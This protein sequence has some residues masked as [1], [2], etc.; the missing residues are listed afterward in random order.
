MAS[1]NADIL[2][3]V[4]YNE[5]SLDRVA[6]TVGRVQALAK[7][8]K[9]IN[10]LKPGA[11]AGA[12]QVAIAMD[13]ILQR[14]KAINKEGTTQIS[15]T[16]AGAAQTAD[17]FAEVLRNV[18][19]T[20]KNGN[21]ELA[22]QKAEV[23]ELA[24]AYAEAAA[25]SETLRNR[26]ESLIAAARQSRGLAIGPAST[27]GTIEADSARAEAAAQARYQEQISKN[28]RTDL[29]YQRL[30][31]E[32]LS[33]QATELL[34]QDTILT[35]ILKKTADYSGG[36]G[37]F[38][39]NLAL[40]VGFPLLFGG[41]A[42]SIA[43]SAIG[44]FFGQG[45]GGQI[46]GGALG[47]ALDQALLKIRDIGNAITTLD[48]DALTDSG[49]RLT[50]QIQAQLNL[51]LQV[52]DTLAAQQIVSQ[53]V[54]RETGTLPGVTEDVANSV[55][56]LSDSWR[57]VSNAISTTVGLIAAPLAVALAG[58]LE[59]VNLLFRGVN[60]IFSLFGTGVK[61][62]AEFV[63]EL[64][65][66]KD[67]LEFINDGISRLNSGLSA[68]TAK[69]AEFRDTL[70][71]SIVR[72]SIE[73][74]A[75]QALTPGATSEDRIANIRVETQKQLNLLYQDEADARIKIRQE[76]AKA[77]AEVVDSL[78]RQ[79]DL[80]FK[81]KKELIET[82]AERQIATEIQREQTRLE[83]EATRAAEKAARE[84]E[85]QRKEM[86]RMAEL[87][88]NQLD[89]AQRN[90]VLAEAAVDIATSNTQESKLQAEFDKVR[91]ERMYTFTDLLKK[92]LS[93][94]ER[95]FI[96]QTQYL[97]SLLDSIKYE[98]ELVDLKKQQTAE[99][100][101]QLD[102]AELLDSQLQKALGRGMTGEGVGV[103]G[104]TLDVNLDPANEAIQKMDEMKQRLEDLSDPIN[105]AVTGAQG[106]G[107]AF[108]AAFQGI[109]T[110]TQTTQEALS[111]FF[112]GVGDAFVS[113]ATEIIAQMVI[114]YAFQQLLGIFG[115]SSG[116]LFSGQGPVTLPAAGVGG[117][118]SMF[119]SSAP[120]FFA[121]GGFVTGPT[122][123]VIGEAGE[124]E[125]VIPASKMRSAMG[126][127]ASGARG[128]SVIPGGSEISNE[129]GGSTAVATAIDV[130][131]S[132]ER[133]NSVDYVTA[134]QFQAG[135][136][137]AA[138]QGAIQGEQ[139]AL[140]KLQQSA[141][142]RNRLGL[143]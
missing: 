101:N 88:R 68:A 102:A 57:K 73:L 65:G 138:A 40:G 9:P 140:R 72:S 61:A 36:A 13:A 87:R 8:I 90:Y 127:Y 132:V 71:Q 117:G 41:G 130:R 115:A 128:S 39:E 38:A 16:Y 120:S 15:A 3:N 137:Q 79:N 86:E 80:L 21:V 48:F 33:K 10:L 28:A 44:S 47:Q 52:G 107:D 59:V 24:G 11:G 143:K 25:K 109:I 133:I 19:I 142:T 108:S 30:R 70:N 60:Q 64:V 124:P 94:E 104:F 126:R 18:N 129:Q 43:G 31:L 49:I 63:I 112:K 22:N 34:E 118:S 123:A 121:E 110:G 103:T 116:S 74:T 119:T 35:R 83:D 77:T 14:A 141:S 17:A 51:L 76:N 46:L 5:R 7:Q 105:A 1:Y 55:N 75:A 134:E 113:M 56:I 26:F 89:D 32:L 98:N 122:S 93:E 99:I 58:I 50:S 96:V 139:L 114:M 84:L 2:L 4:K 135:M 111:D 95:E 42:G 82:S 62:V 97:Q 66:G 136:Q 29:I 6:A 106:I 27:L 23:Q 12:D 67:A 131:Y 20:V 85:R 81:N 45:F 54:A 37:G 100:Y 125:Y 69:A 78:I 91:V 53:E 92:A